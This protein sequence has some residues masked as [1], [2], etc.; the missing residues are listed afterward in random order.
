MCRHFYFYL[1]TLSIPDCSLSLCVETWC[2]DTLNVSGFHVSTP[3]EHVSTLLAH[4]FSPSQ[5][6][7][8]MFYICTLWYF[9]CWLE[10]VIYHKASVHCM[11]HAGWKWHSCTKSFNGLHPLWWNAIILLLGTFNWDMGSLPLDPIH[12][13]RY[14]IEFLFCICLVLLMQLLGLKLCTMLHLSK[15]LPF[16][17]SSTDKYIF[18]RSRLA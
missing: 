2:V 14:S 12:F 11:P 7:R 18:N 5:A 15:P 17:I 3:Q 6:L 13:W 9:I 10:M 1:S 16:C 8:I 4:K